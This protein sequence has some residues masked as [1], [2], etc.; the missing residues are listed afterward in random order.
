MTEEKFME[1]IE[2]YI[3][4]IIIGTMKAKGLGQYSTEDNRFLNFET[5]S[6]LKEEP[7]EKT[8]L[9]LVGKQIVCLF[10]SMNK[11]DGEISLSTLPLFDELVKDIIIYML[12]LRGMIHEKTTVF[13]DPVSPFD[14]ELLQSLLSTPGHGS[15]VS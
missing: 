2:G 11:F 14:T 13:S 12:L 7:R 5:L 8:L 4:D 3:K 10:Q 6:I 15:N 9:G 1:Y